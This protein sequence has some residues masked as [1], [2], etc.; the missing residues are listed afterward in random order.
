MS[1]ILGSSD[2][3]SGAV[4]AGGRELRDVNGPSWDEADTT[5]S[6]E[7]LVPLSQKRGLLDSDD[8]DNEYDNARDQAAKD[9]ESINA[10]IFCIFSVVFD[11]SEG[12]ILEWCAPPLLP[13]P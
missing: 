4:N 3:E 2:D 10:K 12:P 9:E 1:D 5:P 11:E 7:R 8:E 6:K 13:R